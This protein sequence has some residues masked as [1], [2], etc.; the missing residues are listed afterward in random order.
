MLA[1]RS[2]A[3]CLLCCCLAFLTGGCFSG[4]VEGSRLIYSLMSQLIISKDNTCYMLFNSIIYLIHIEHHRT[5]TAT[6]KTWGYLR[7]LHKVQGSCHVLPGPLRFLLTTFASAIT[8]LDHRPLARTMFA[9]L[10]NIS[11]EKNHR[12]EKKSKRSEHTKML[13]YAQPCLTSRFPK[14]E[15][16]HVYMW[17]YPR[18]IIHPFCSL[19]FCL[20][21]N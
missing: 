20:L 5:A 14:W 1:R 4:S 3:S 7:N 11:L 12:A 13:A 15:S 17:R 10:G 21:I 9:C 19:N 8:V 18:Y 6:N 2:G 16:I